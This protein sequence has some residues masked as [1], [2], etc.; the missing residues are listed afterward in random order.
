MPGCNSGSC[1]FVVVDFLDFLVGV[2]A[3]LNSSNGLK[4]WDWLCEL[5]M[6]SQMIA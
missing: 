1:F 4:G 3:F 2:G 5:M 6:V